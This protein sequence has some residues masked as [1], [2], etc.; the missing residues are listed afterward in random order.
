MP[1]AVIEV[2]EKLLVITRE[3]FI[4][5]A[6]RHFVGEVL[7]VSDENVRVQGYA[8][9]Y[10][11]IHYKYVKKVE[12]RTRIFSLSSAQLIFFILPMEVSISSLHYDS[13]NVNKLSLVDGSGFSLNLDEFSVLD[14]K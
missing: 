11:W 10:D 8:Q 14:Q 4:G 6:R 12:L 7:A 13:S 3:N 1:E 2:G 5:D 9:V